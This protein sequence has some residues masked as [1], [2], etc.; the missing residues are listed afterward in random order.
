[1][2]T[3]QPAPMWA[4]LRAPR[5]AL[6]LDIDGTLLEFESHPD[7]VRA[8]RGL[9]LLLQSASEVLDGAL[10][11]ISGRPLADI[12]RVFGPWQPFAAGGHGAEVRGPAGT[13]H[14]HVDEQMVHGLRALADAE[15]EGLPGVWIEDKGYGFAV[16]Y[17]DHP[18]HEPAV[19]TLAA[20]IAA[21]SGGTL[22]VQPGVFVQ[23]LRPAAFDKGLALD[24]LMEQGPFK[25]RR[26]VVV[27][28]DRTDEYAFEAAHRHGGISILVGPRDD[29]VA[30][31]RIS[32][33]EGVRAWLA[34][35]TEEV[36]R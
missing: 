22:K 16:H 5:P 8:T 28:D 2:R 11:L 30:R 13:R 35:I 18:E 33:P 17:R 20:E 6:F 12:D 32:D 3:L 14:H 19:V 23:E 26:P 4:E 31:Y 24:E 36:G 1:M 9:I 7:L 29:T 21:K 27:G 34:Q 15:V 10:A 25:G